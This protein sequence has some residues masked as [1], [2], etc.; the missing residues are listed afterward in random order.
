M[1][2]RYELNKEDERTTLREGIIKA[3]RAIP[4]HF[5]TPNL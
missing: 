2:K 5:F 3:L 4:L 1:A